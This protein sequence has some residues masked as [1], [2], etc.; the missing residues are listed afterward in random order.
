M[1]SPEQKHDIAAAVQLILRM[2]HNPELPAWE[3]EF[4]LHVRGAE[5]WSWADIKN[6]GRV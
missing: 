3:I 5:S 4:D 6:N 2:T 1:F